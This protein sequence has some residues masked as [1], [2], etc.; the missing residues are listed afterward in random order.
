MRWF[1]SLGRSQSTPLLRYVVDDDLGDGILFLL[2]SMIATFGIRGG[3]YDAMM[4][5]AKAA[6]VG[7]D[8]V[9]GSMAMSLLSA[10]AAVAA[11]VVAVAARR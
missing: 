10:A 2:S 8:D 1:M 11:V 4:L 7:G 5:L 9:G 3:L 6:V